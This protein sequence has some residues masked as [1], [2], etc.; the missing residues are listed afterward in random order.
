MKALRNA[1]GNPVDELEKLLDNEF[2]LERFRSIF[3]DPNLLDG[4]D[5]LK[6]LDNKTVFDQIFEVTN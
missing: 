1:D 4:R 3:K 6:H 2:M 5:L